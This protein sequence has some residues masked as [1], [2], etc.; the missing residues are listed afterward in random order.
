MTTTSAATPR[1]PSGPPSP[2]SDQSAPS[3]G[4]SA[5]GIR[6]QILH[7]PDCPLVDE[8]RS[9]LDR[10]LS[11]IAL[12]TTVEQIEGPY[13][14]PTLLVNGTDPTG[15]RATNGP[16]CRLDLPTEVEVLAALAQAETHLQ[17]LLPG[18]ED[19]RCA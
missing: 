9:L 2:Q 13:G 16:S 1:R 14:S 6:V 8:M 11:R 4:D 7:V 3:K 12:R 5:P 17:L 18:D 19:E 15:R 10:C